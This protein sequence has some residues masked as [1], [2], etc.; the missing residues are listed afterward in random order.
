MTQ[1]KI[2]GIFA[3]VSRVLGTVPVGLL[4][5][6][7]QTTT[8]D[9][10]VVN[11]FLPV[12][13]IQAIVEPASRERLME[14]GLDL[15]ASYIEVFC[16]TDIGDLRRNATADRVAWNGTTWDAEYSEPWHEINGWRATVCRDLLPGGTS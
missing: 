4:R 5:F 6:S 10:I 9:G 16:A 13:P 8:A 14:L 2:Q 12:T 15:R 11:N 1:V 3:K 7:G